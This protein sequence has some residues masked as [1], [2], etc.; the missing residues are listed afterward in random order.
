MTVDGSDSSSRKSFFRSKEELELE[1]AKARMEA[2][3]AELK[4]KALEIEQQLKERRRSKR[5]ASDSDASDPARKPAAPSINNASDGPPNQ[6]TDATE[7]LHERLLDVQQKQ[8]PAVIDSPSPQLLAGRLDSAKEKPSRDDVMPV[9]DITDKA[10]TCSSER[11]KR[12][13]QPGRRPI[14]KGK[15]QDHRKHS[16]R[17][18]P[19]KEAESQDS[20]LNEVN[21]RGKERTRASKDEPRKTADASGVKVLVSKKGHARRFILSM[22][23]W[24]L[25]A[26]LHFIILVVLGLTVMPLA[27]KPDDIFITGEAEISQ[28]EE[29]EEVE[30]ETESL[31]EMDELETES[32]EF[33]DMGLASL[34]EVAS[35][36]N[37]AVVGDAGP[38]RTQ[39]AASEFGA[40][41]GSGGD[42]LGTSGAGQGGAQFF[43][44]QA[45]GSEFAFVVD[46]S[47]SMRSG[48]G[49]K[50]TAALEEL[51]SA[52]SRLNPKQ[53]FF[54]VFYS[55][56]PDPMFGEHDRQRWPVR[57]SKDNLTKLEQ[58]L[59]SVEPANKAQTTYL[60]L[61]LE[62]VIEMR[63]DATF[64]LSDGDL[65]SEKPLKY[66]SEANRT[67][68]DPIFGETR[69]TVVHTVCF[70]H[71]VS[72]KLQTIATDNGGTY[73]NHPPPRALK[74][75]R[76]LP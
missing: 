70:S 41:L 32:V 11:D 26:L 12:V 73:T 53:S 30:F 48:G 59:Q 18:A 25:S 55:G 34:T 72:E 27:L 21:L 50:W 43:G 61:A 9:G 29:L 33:E 46:R 20:A 16:P 28:S 47:A 39:S 35:L 76:R 67:T 51:V 6:A 5:T 52:V 57:A 36:T 64:I 60:E 14:I 40:L 2:E 15:A 49:L 69:P 24:L 44:S 7:V 17:K 68:Y 13:A 22:P 63:P 3:A 42:G 38:A 10:T 74:S 54:V 8:T 65:Y 66:L 45:G 1:L 75:P 62:L 71:Q 4:L 31:E 23:G 56:D 37:P 58:W 19:T